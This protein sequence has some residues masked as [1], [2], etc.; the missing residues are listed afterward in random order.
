MGLKQ[1]IANQLELVRKNSLSLLDPLDN[2]QL[3]TQ[4]SP[5][6]S[7]LVWDLAHVGNYEDL[8]L[9]RELGSTAYDPSYDDIYDAFSHPRSQRPS[10]DL[11]SPEKARIYISEIRKRALDVL[12]KTSLDQP[13]GSVDNSFIY[14]LVIQHE[15][16]HDETILA[17]LQLMKDPLLPPKPAPLLNKVPTQDKETLIPGGYFRMGTDID[18][19]AYDNER[20]SYEVFVE[21]FFMDT[22]P[23]TNGEF[24]NFMLDQGYSNPQY[25]TDKGWEWVQSG[26]I[27]SPL[28]WS[29]DSKGSWI[30]NRFGWEEAIDP[31]EPVQ[32]VSWYEADAFARWTNKRLPTEVEW[33]K[34]AS[35]DPKSN[36]KARFPWGNADPDDSKAN[37][38]HLRF[39]PTRI[40]TYPNSVSKYG[41]HQMIGDV[42]EWVGNNFTPYPGYQSFPYDEYSKVFFGSD[43]KVLKGGSWASSSQVARNTFR[44]WDFPQRRQIFS[45]FR[46]A[47]S[48]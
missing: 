37:L 32:H 12:D 40:G 44:N 11:L 21:D 17:T 38:N 14:R 39:G 1:T 42:W 45:G 16:Q 20:P 31:Q 23:V 4:H 36:S 19:W 26:N 48:I 27:K 35:W 34:A 30:R 25:W 47:R 5:L 3:T 28:F 24:L 18:P 33:E 22:F 13:K 2:F 29:Q 15:H 41:I 46:C 6:M 10:L 7:P 43:Y 9:L 8:W